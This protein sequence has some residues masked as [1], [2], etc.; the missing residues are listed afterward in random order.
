M[1]NYTKATNFAAK[2]SLPSGNSGKIIKG[3]EIDTEFNAIASAVASKTD[4]N[5]PAFTGTPTAPTAVAGTDTTQLATTAFVNTAVTNERTATATLTN[6]TLT[7][8]TINGGTVSSLSTPLA[9]ASG[10]T[11]TTTPSLVA[12][13]GITISGS[14]PN[15]TITNSATGVTSAVAGNG[16][17]VSGATDAV[18]FNVACPTFNTVGSYVYYYMFVD[19]NGTRTI[20]SGSNYSA[21]AGNLQIQSFTYSTYAGNL[22]SNN[23]SGTWKH[24]GASG[25]VNVYA[26][27]S[28]NVQA[29]ACRVS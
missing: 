20:N 22:V 2:D 23:L 17:S 1:A 24:M 26:G 21:G 7:S 25:T 14:F 27:G 6:K 29:I 12:G 11:G 9:V 13:T 18:T 16:I 4:S 10:G 15:Q 8:P 19:D 3:T 5:S 28:H